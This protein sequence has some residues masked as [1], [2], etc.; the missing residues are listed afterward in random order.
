MAPM[1][2]RK[3]KTFAAPVVAGEAKKLAFGERTPEQIA[4][5]K[6][7]A[8]EARAEKK[9]LVERIRQ[10]EVT[11]ED[12]F[13]D[14]FKH[15]ERAQRLLIGTALRALP[16]VTQHRAVKIEAEV[17]ISKG[18]RIQGVGSRQRE[19]LLELVK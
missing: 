6:R 17:G 13:S 15:N 11:L 18:R 7:A 9:I 5:A 3:D 16:N 14:A 4:S 2:K 10:G 19:K 12:L 8:D 1:F